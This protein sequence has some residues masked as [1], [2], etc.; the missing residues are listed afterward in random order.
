MGAALPD[1]EDEVREELQKIGGRG[2]KR[3]RL[4]V[5]RGRSLRGSSCPTGLTAHVLALALPTCLPAY[6]QA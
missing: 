5:W 2:C 6:P 3:R 1:D 4:L